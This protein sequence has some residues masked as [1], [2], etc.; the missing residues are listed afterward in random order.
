[1]ANQEANDLN[2]LVILENFSPPFL[3]SINTKKKRKKYLSKLRRAHRQNKTIRERR[4]GRRK[5]ARPDG[6]N[7]QTIVLVF[8][9]RE[10][11]GANAEGRRI[12]G[13]EGRGG[14]GGVGGGGGMMLAKGRRKEREEGRELAKE[15]GP[16]QDFREFNIVLGA[17]ADS[18]GV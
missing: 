10:F 6:G 14:R 5:V 15:R 16:S 7:D 9:S 11:L 12:T 2:D 1:M 4:R 8:R 13:R 18:L 17:S 3:I